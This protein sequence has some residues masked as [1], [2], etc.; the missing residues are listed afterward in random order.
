MAAGNEQALSDLYDATLSKVFGV[1]VR[2]LGDSVLAEDVVTEV[3]YQ[4]WTHA[5]DFRRERGTPL[6]WLL[7]MCRNRALD[8]YRHEA[9]KQRTLEAASAEPTPDVVAEPDFLLESLEEG[10]AV[11]ALLASIADDDR[12]LIALAF[13]RGFTHQQIA[14]ITSMPIGTVKSRLRRALQ[15]LGKAA[16]VDQQVGSTVR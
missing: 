1:A 5:S 10:Q 14:A 13:F 9:S 7:T 15:T 2:I 3:Y 16:S 8:R 11:H 12:Q 4:A 6:A